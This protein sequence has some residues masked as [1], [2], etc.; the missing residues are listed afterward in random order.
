[1]E[2]MKHQKPMVVFLDINMPQIKGIDIAS[3]ILEDSPD[4]EIIFVTAYDEYALEA[5]E[6]HAIDYL[7]KPVKE[8]RLDKTINRLRKKQPLKPEKSTAKLQIKCFGC[9][10]LRWDNKEP[11]KWRAEKTKELF[12]FLIHKQGSVITKDEILDS[13]WSEDDPDKAIRQL[14]NGIYYI[15]KA[16]EEYGVDHR[17]LCIDSNYNMKLGDIQ[18]DLNYLNELRSNRDTLKI[19]ELENET[20]LLAG[21]YMGKEDYQW[22]FAAKEEYRV[23]H[24]DCLIK[25]AKSYMEDREYE[26]AERRLLTAYK[27]DPYHEAVTELLMKLYLLM[28]DKN[29]GIKHFRD[30]VNLMKEELGVKP[31]LK[32][33]ELYHS[34]HMR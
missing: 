23:L 17:L 18:F 7:L 27:L 8:E 11:I 5:F 4:T 30:Y 22:A 14:Y 15:R 6:L 2:E 19:R 34:M 13:L 20:E 25:L 24:Q 21:E 26:L 12:A 29:K 31:G 1:M 16:L 28:Q 9:F 32:I 10:Q 33:I 3:S